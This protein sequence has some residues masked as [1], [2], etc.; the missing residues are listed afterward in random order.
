VGRN[1][2]LIERYIM[3]R[4]IESYLKV[5]SNWFSKEICEETVNELEILKNDFH[6]HAYYDYTNNSSKSYDYDLSCSDVTVKHKEFLMKR[7]WDGLKDYHKKLGFEWYS[8]WQGYSAIRFNRYDVN[9][10]MKLHCDHIHSLFEGER[11]GI[12]TL[13]I[14]GALNN[15]YKGGELVLWNDKIIELKAGEIMIFP[16][17][18]LYPHEVKFVT[19]GTR[20]SFVSWT[21]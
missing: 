17:N 8:S 10:R 16:S 11:K 15:D 4:N 13:T 14:L 19:E 18:F 12:P 6:K 7:I 2:P 20:Y 3:D 5:Y 1:A 9:T 21:W